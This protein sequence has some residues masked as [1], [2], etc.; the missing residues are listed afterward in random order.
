MVCEIQQVTSVNHVHFENYSNVISNDYCKKL[1]R[2]PLV[3]EAYLAKNVPKSRLLLMRLFTG[4][5]SWWPITVWNLISIYLNLRRKPPAGLLLIQMALVVNLRE[6]FTVSDRMSRS[7]WKRNYWSAWSNLKLGG[8]Q[9]ASRCYR[10]LWQSMKSISNF[11]RWLFWAISQGPFGG[12]GL[13]KISPPIFLNGY[14]LA[15]G[16][17][18]IDLQTMLM[19][20]DICL[21]TVTSLP[22]LTVWK[23]YSHILPCKAG[24][25]L[26]LQMF[27]PNYQLL[28]NGEILPDCICYT[29]SIVR[30]SHFS[31]HIPTGTSFEWNS[32]LQSV[33]KYQSNLTLQCIRWSR[34]SQLWVNILCPNWRWLRTRSY[35]TGAWI[36]QDCTWRWYVYQI[37]E[38]AVVPLST[39]SL[40]FICWLSGTQLEGRISWCQPRAHAWI[41]EGLGPIY[42]QWPRWHLPRSSFILF[43]N[44]L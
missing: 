25:I 28:I 35:W 20:L 37:T 21:S 7:E 15:M 42:R 24:I 19:S 38:W 4:Q 34:N 5:K 36:W 2:N 1:A 40:P 44:I 31:P 17:W 6:E 33:Q 39:I 3:R 11:R 30:R 22:V 41:S 9:S 23:R 29:S 13:V 8:R 32:H 12:W 27:I 26:A 10:K 18:H 43:C 14:I 16:K